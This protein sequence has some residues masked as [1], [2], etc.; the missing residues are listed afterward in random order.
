[1]DLPVAIQNFAM[2]SIVT[3]SAIFDWNVQDHAL[4]AEEI[5]YEIC[6]EFFLFA[7]KKNR[8]TLVRLVLALP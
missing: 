5:L 7:C 8:E 3:T 6:L 2:S 1:M 4:S